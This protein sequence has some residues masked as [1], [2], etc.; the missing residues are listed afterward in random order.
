[1]IEDDVCSS[2]EV[3]LAGFAVQEMEPLEAQARGFTHGHRKVYGIPEAMSANVLREFQEF[4]A[5]KPDVNPSDFFTESKRAL[6][7]CAATLQYEAATLPATQL[8]Q[9]V[10][11]EKFTQ[12][13]LDGCVGNSD[14]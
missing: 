3:G 2:G 9:D 14:G 13:L 6:I 11:A 7:E 5:G 10:P 1:M 8:E 12:R 4:S